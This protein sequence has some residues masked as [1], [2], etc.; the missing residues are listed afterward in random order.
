MISLKITNP[1][2]CNHEFL[3]QLL[4]CNGTELMSGKKEKLL[5]LNIKK[6]TPKH[7]FLISILYDISYN[8]S[9]LWYKYYK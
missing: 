8:L 5:N 6:K 7:S 2:L 4:E 3:L 9:H 1:I